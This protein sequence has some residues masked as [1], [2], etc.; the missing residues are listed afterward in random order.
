MLD[1][2]LG[3]L[4]VSLLARH[5]PQFATLFLNAGA[6]IQHH[7]M[8]NSSAYRGPRRNPTWYVAHGED[9]LL[10]IYQAY[11]QLVER[12]CRAYA[13]ARIVIATALHQEPYP[14][15]TFYWRLRDHAAFLASIGCTFESVEALMSRDFVI[16]FGTSK[17]AQ[18]AAEL[19]N[20]ARLASEQRPVFTIDNRGQSLFCTLVYDCEIAPDDE[21]FVNGK[22]IRFRPDV[23]FVAV[24]NAHHSGVGYLIDTGKASDLQPL[25][26]TQ[27]FSSVIEHFGVQAPT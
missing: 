13:S 7:Y 20:G 1:E 8:F 18:T 9:P 16:R 23:D 14:N 5:R 22:S 3:D 4:F 2:L 10:E 26:I 15:E 25:P 11:D 19:L 12:I 6:H 17:D 21:L 24:K 27:L